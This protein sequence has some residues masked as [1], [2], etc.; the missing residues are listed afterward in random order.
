M[1]NAI[2]LGFIVVLDRVLDKIP[3]IGRLEIGILQISID[4]VV[5]EARI[6]VRKIGLRVVDLRRD[7]ELAI[8]SAGGLHGING[9]ATAT[10]LQ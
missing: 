3:H 6:V 1:A 2:A 9:I 8:I 7:Q 4:G 10:T 5:R